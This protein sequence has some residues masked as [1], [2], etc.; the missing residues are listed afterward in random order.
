[1]IHAH[2]TAEVAV[3]YVQDAVIPALKRAASSD[4]YLRWRG[5]SFNPVSTPFLCLAVSCTVLQ[6]VWEC[7]EMFASVA[8]RVLPSVADVERFADCCKR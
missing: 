3:K 1:M 2:M 8:E 4:V 6:S 5:L 7:C